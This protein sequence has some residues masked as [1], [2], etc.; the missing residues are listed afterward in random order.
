MVT[1]WLYRHRGWTAV[2][3]AVA[4]VWGARPTAWSLGV[5]LL[6]VVAFEALR[7]A[8]LRYAGAHTRGRSLRAPHL[9]TGGPY[10]RMR[11]PLYVGNAGVCAG[12]LVA[13]RAGWPWFPALVAG[14]F[15]VQYALFI[16]HEERFLAATF[17]PVWHDYAAAVPAAGWGSGLRPGARPVL[18]LPEALRVEFSTLRTILVL[19]LLVA[20]RPLWR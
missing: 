13:S 3:L 10:A 4:L 16:R 15:L 14:A 17:G 2:P 7:V 11:H 8:A 9:A 19:S 6:L 20:L 5:G 12:L 1:D 18:T